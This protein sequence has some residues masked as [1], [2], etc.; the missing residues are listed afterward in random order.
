MPAQHL[1]WTQP[2]RRR[3]WRQRLG[4]SA[5]ALMLAAASGMALGGNPFQTDLS[6]TVTDEATAETPG[7][8]VIYRIVAR[9]A[10]SVTAA[11]ATVTDSF[12]AALSSCSW[13]C[14]ASTGASCPGNGTGNIAAA[15]TLPAAASA[16]FHATCLIDAGATGTL[17]NTASIAPP[18]GITDPNPGNDSATD[19]DTLDAV[20]PARTQAHW[21]LTGSGIP[22]ARSELGMAHDPVSRQTLLF[23]GSDLSGNPYLNDLYRYQS[24]TGW[25]A[26]DAGTSL[27]AGRRSFSSA[28]GNGSFYV[29]GGIGPGQSL[30][31]DIW[32]YT[33]GSGWTQLNDGSGTPHP[34]ARFYLTG[35]AL[36]DPVRN[37]F[38]FFG[39]RNGAGQA[40]NQTWAFRLADNTWE[41]LDAGTGSNAPAGREGHRLV[42][43]PDLDAYLLFGGARTGTAGAHY[44][45]VW[46]FKPDEADGER[47][48]LRDPGSDPNVPAFAPDRPTGRRDAAL[49]YDA[50][51]RR[52]VMHGGIRCCSVY[53]NETWEY[54]AATNRWREM[55]ILTPVPAQASSAG[56]AFDTTIDR[57]V[58]AAGRDS[59]NAPHSETYE[60]NL[61]PALSIADATVT[62]GDSGTAALTFTVSLNAP[63]L[64]GGVSFDIATAD[65]GA[66]APDDYIARALTGQT[67]AQG[68]SSA[69]F[70]VTVN[71]D[72]LVE[73]DES[74]HVRV[75]NVVG[76]TLADGEATGTILND[77]FYTSPGAPTAVA[78]TAGDTQ[79]T[80]S[81]TAPGDDGG[82]AITGYTVSATPGS[83]TCTAA[84]PQSS[85]TVATLVNGTP[86]TFRVMAT[87][88]IGDGPLSKASTAVTPVGPQSI[89]FA[90]NPGPIAF[91]TS[92]I[93]A[94]TASSGQPVSYGVTVASAT[95]CSIDAGTG[96]I[97]TVGVGN[98][99]VTADQA[100]NAAFLPAP[101]ASQTVVI[102]PGAQA[103]LTAIATPASIAF[104][105]SSALSTSGG[106][107]TGAVSYVVTTGTTICS[108]AGS[109]LTGIGVGTCTV[110]ATKAADANFSAATATV[111]ISVGLAPQATL[112]AIATPASIAFNGSSALSTSGGSGT[113]AV[114]YVVTT[115][116]TICSVAGSTLTGIAVGTCTV[117]ATKTADANFSAATATVA[118]TVEGT[119]PAA[120]GNVTVT[121]NGTTATI[122]WT[123]P[124]ATGGLPLTG[125]TATLQP[126]GAGCT[127]TP[128]QTQCTIGGLLPGQTYAIA[129]TASNAMGIGAA[130][131]GSGTVPGGIAPT[132]LAIPATN[133]WT[134]LLLGLAMLAL[135]GRQR[136][137]GH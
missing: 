99:V 47:W 59:G 108:V 54:D 98:C 65:G 120:P 14:I 18:A 112:T 31:A 71:G 97:T 76:A 39:G 27:P 133:R 3:D 95:V 51:R 69:S 44:N 136:E 73:P 94:A 131:V 115:G 60:L 49:T 63:A 58:I 90:A 24:G 91:G 11:G 16:T 38:V 105:G 74:L 113:G 80:V 82:S 52:Y 55:E 92:G 35:G 13:I 62:E 37:R 132:P 129:V 102:T 42:Y 34:G 32:R 28:A 122:S 53:Y 36:Y 93:A 87:N 77:D 67:I 12:P 109:T 5:V 78:A 86:Y 103:T 46:L 135:A 26:V 118:L 75:N 56:I 134:L 22:S 30:L 84:A 96:V 33:P 107:G 66:T 21:T 7:S 41:L 9:N 19:S 79:A 128:P 50:L 89:S 57:V 137:R 17:V 101:Q 123:A 61:L 126:G 83:A 8:V 4:R 127:A 2:L 104:N 111:D 106:S 70:T 40:T 119:V 10:G 25:A 110:T 6:I 125:Y 81:W 117:T 116:T 130:A 23:G 124:A 68:T 43:D 100:G 48:Q 1:V 64:A 29:Y 121:F 20:L 72:T 114:S 88:T 85:C 15:I 45:D